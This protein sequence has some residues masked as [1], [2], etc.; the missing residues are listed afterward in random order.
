M[1]CLGVL[2]AV[3][4]VLAI[5]MPADVSQAAVGP[6]IVEGTVYD[7]QGD[8]LAMAHVSVTM[9]SGDVARTTLTVYTDE[10]GWYRVTFGPSDWDVGNSIVVVVTV[11]NSQ[12]VEQVLAD[13]SPLQIID[14]HFLYA[15][16]EF[17]IIGGVIAG[18]V[19]GILALILLRKRHHR[20][21]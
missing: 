5:V 10:T 2:I 6:K 8:R 7:Y 12:Q 16:P 13:E 3:L 1:R 15:I 19:V 21:Q 9:F 17:G 20:A 14:V 4:G 11:G 18:I